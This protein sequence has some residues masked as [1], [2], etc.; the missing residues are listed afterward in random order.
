IAATK[1]DSILICQSEV[2]FEERVFE[3][4][5]PNILRHA[6][7]NERPEWSRAHGCNVRKR[8]RKCLVP[9]Q[10]SRRGSAMKINSFNQQIR[11]KHQV[12]IADFGDYRRVIAYPGKHARRLLSRSSFFAKAAN[13]IEFLHGG[14]LKI[15]A[16]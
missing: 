13:E 6:N 15:A 5:P 4:V 11:G 14:R 3:I 1:R 16:H 12:A 8:N 7:G 10:V 2:P 9:E